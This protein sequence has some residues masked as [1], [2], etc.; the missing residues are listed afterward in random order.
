[1]RQ[2]QALQ[3]PQ[4]E[5]SNP[6]QRKPFTDQLQHNL[7][8]YIASYSR[9][10]YDNLDWEQEID[11]LRNPRLI[12]PTY[13]LAPHHGMPEGYLS[14]DQA[15]GWAFVE[16]FFRVTRALPTLL[17]IA[18]SMPSRQIVDLGC[19]I[20][21]ASLALAQRFPEAHLTLLDLSPYQLAAARRQAQL[22][23][24]DAR[25]CY[26]HTLAEHTGLADNSADLVMST[27]LFHELPRLQARE[28]VRETRRILVPG[29]RFIE[30]DPIQHALPWHWADM[31]INKLLAKM[32]REVYWLEYMRQP[33]WEV[34]QDMG[35]TQVERRLIFVLPW[36][37][38][39]IIATK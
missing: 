19:G 39:V 37:Y 22:Q 10:V 23:G 8:N 38:Q 7:E 32:I 1:M 14:R 17:D 11:E 29:G 15:I 3:E 12:Y 21:T 5:T 33:V 18:S 25:T 4:T 31:A 13:Y 35:F 28:V 34:C 26:M 2:L 36:I 30:F 16:R 24:I 9:G 20:A 27:L 6:I